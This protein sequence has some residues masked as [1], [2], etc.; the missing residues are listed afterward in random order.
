MGAMR[1]G[2]ISDI[3]GNLEALETA[4]A[5]IDRSG[6]ESVICLGDVVGYGANPN[7]CVD[8]VRTKCDVVILGN[9]DSA[10]VGST[11]IESFTRRARISTEWTRER[12]SEKNKEYLEGLPLTWS[13]DGIFAVHA[14]PLEPMEWRY[15]LRR[16]HAGE[17]FRHFEEPVCFVGHSHVP[18]IFRES[19]TRAGAPVTDEILL[20]ETD[21]YLINIGSVGQPRDGDAR[22]SWGL[23]DS[24]K[25]IVRLF[26]EEYDH[27][28]ASEKIIHAGLPEELGKRLFFGM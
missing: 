10:V 8:A 23:Y 19:G 2:L 5:S 14:S 13:G 18:V 3:H 1:Y 26:R 21:R 12:L 20:D 17:A 25:R 11:S 6:V 9:H 15:V 28:T 27:R 7:G 4:F 16:E 22:L 24:E